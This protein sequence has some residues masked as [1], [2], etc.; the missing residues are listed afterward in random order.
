MTGKEQTVFRAI[1]DPTRRAILAHLAGEDLTIAQLV[2]R[3]DVT[4][5][6]IKKHLV[7][8]EE[9]GVI[10]VHP[11]GRERVNRLEAAALKEV[12]DWVDGFSRFWDERLMKLKAAVEAEEK[13]HG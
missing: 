7:I 4:R 11:R 1:A 13:E 5:G 9:G 2:G 3:F 8:L 6:A 10:S 12:A